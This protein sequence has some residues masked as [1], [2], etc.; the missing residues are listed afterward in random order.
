M[1]S[2]INAD[3]LLQS[4]ALSVA[5]NQVG[6]NRP[7]QEVLTGEGLTQQEYDQISKNPQYQRYLDAYVRDLS[8]NGFSFS[9]KARILAEDLLPTTYHMIKDPDVPAAV[10][11]KGIENLV[12]WAKLKPKNES[13]VAESSRYSISIVINGQTETLNA[14]DAK[15]S[16][17][18]VDAVPVFELPEPKKRLPTPIIFDEPDSYE[19][20]GDDIYV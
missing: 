7:L 20:A 16:A 3:G 12:E 10:R 15:Q 11:M 14:P 9:A 4:L 8:D 13:V 19:Y 1:H 18:D 5:R 6:A 17:I 2:A